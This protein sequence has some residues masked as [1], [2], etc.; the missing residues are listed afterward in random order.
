M[1]GRVFGFGGVVFGNEIFEDGTI[2]IP[3][4]ISWVPSNDRP[5]PVTPSLVEHWGRF[6]FTLKS[7]QTIFSRLLRADSAVAATRIL[8]GTQYVSGSGLGL[9]GFT[10]RFSNGTVRNG[11]LDTS[12]M[13]YSFVV[14]PAVVDTRLGRALMVLDTL[15][16]AE[17]RDNLIRQAES[18]GVPADEISRLKIVLTSDLGQYKFTDVKLI[19]TRIA[20]GPITV[21]RRFEG[22]FRFIEPL[23][24]FF[25]SKSAAATRS[26]AFIT[27]LSFDGQKPRAEAATP[28]YSIIPMLTEISDPFSRANEF[29]EA[30]ALL[31]WGKERGAAFAGPMPPVAGLAAV[32]A[33]VI[34][35]DGRVTYGSSQAAFQEVTVL[36][37]SKLCAEARSGNSKRRLD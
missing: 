23:Q 4:S 9:V 16:M 11:S 20:G 29:S 15:P 13:G 10:S 36:S 22:W 30:F 34:G 27:L 21:E 1:T 25:E 18:S 33:V 3:S 32:T 6:Q 17:V 28:I 24:K 2:G 26:K 19:V 35:S 37:V 14:H 5:S 31:R 8:F 7:G 12:E